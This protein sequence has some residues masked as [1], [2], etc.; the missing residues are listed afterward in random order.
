MLK[1]VMCESEQDELGV[2]Q[3]NSIEKLD[4]NVEKYLER[5]EEIIEN[6]DNALARAEYAGIQTITSSTAITVEETLQPVQA[7]DKFTAYQDLKPKYLI[8]VMFID[9][10]K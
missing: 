4:A 1:G 9:G 8:L 10:Y 7:L 2:T 6:K 5:Y 3:E